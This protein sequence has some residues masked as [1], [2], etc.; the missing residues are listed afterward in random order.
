VIG[1]DGEDDLGAV[2][3]PALRVRQRGQD[4]HVG[5]G[6]GDP[7]LAGDPEIEQPVLQVHGDLLRTEQRDALDPIVVDRTVVVAVR[8]AA[9][10]EVGVL[11]Q[12]K[13]LLLEGA[14]R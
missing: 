3:R 10:P 8:A 1:G 12:S 13:R 7:V 14:L 6:L 2:T 11:E 5:L 4:L 9:D